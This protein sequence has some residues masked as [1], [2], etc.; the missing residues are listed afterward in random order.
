MLTRYRLIAFLITLSLSPILPPIAQAQVT[1]MA[2]VPTSGEWLSGDE[3][4]KAYTN[5][6]QTGM[7]SWTRNDDGIPVSFS[8]TH[9]D[10]TI[11]TYNEF[12]REDFTIK[13][14]WTVKKNII[15]YYYDDWRISP[16]NCFTVLKNGNCYYH[17]DDAKAPNFQNMENWNSVSFNENETPTCVPP[18]S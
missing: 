3:I 6:T 2:D 9:Y 8:E 11:T 5:T 10:N 17:Y 12:G 1:N 14:V 7:Y 13:G 18:I 4:L 16:V 15:C